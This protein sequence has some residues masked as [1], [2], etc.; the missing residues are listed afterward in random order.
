MAGGVQ[1]RNT[2]AQTHACAPTRVPLPP[3]PNNLNPHLD[4]VDVGLED[5]EVEA[6]VAPH[7]PVGPRID[8]EDERALFGVVC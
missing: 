3:L 1:D 4:V 5:Q 8:V 6:A 7:L 2:Y